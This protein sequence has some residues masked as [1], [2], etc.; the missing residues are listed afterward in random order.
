[1]SALQASS[2]E[3]TLLIPANSMIDSMGCAERRFTMESPA[4]PA[5]AGTLD[6]VSG[7]PWFLLLGS[8]VAGL[9]G[10]VPQN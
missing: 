3:L 10:F 5:N 6:G 4:R 2:N 9:V 1:M 8:V 7:L